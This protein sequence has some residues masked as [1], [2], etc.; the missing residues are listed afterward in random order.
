MVGGP[1]ARVLRRQSWG[2]AGVC[3]RYPSSSR[4]ESAQS[5]ECPCPHLSP[6]TPAPDGPRYRFRK[7]D[8]VLFYGRKIMR[9]VSP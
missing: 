2:F 8:K 4:V 5:S 7:R 1:N 9:K 6:E 3:S